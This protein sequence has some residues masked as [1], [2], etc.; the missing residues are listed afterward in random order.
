MG[1]LVGI[2]WLVV[3]LICGAAGAWLYLRRG[4][5]PDLL[6]PVRESLDRFDA[7]V[8]ELE[9]SRQ[10]AYGELREQVRGLAEGQE[11]LRSEAGRLASALRAPTVRGRWGEVQLRR[12][13]ELAGMV[14]HCD[15]LEQPTSEDG[16]H[17]PDMV[18]TL[19]GGR[20][21]VVDAKAPLHRYLDAVEAED[22][23]ARE[24]ALREHARHVRAHIARLSAKSYWSRFDDAPEF[25]V[26]FLPGEA[27]FSAALEQDPEL[28]EAGADDRVILAT[29]T[30]LIALLRSVAYGWR[31]E[32]V[33]RNAQEISELGREL[34]GRLATL[35]GH[36]DGVGRNLD[37][38]VRA[39]NDAVGSLEAR[40]L[41]SARRFSELGAVGDD[42]LE[43]PA[44]VVSMTRSVDIAERDV[45]G[46]PVDVQELDDGPLDRG[47]GAPDAEERTG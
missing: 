36:L 31:Q 32:Q 3:G 24:R 19:P 23:G 9:A 26:L 5:E 37:R 4:A 30:T 22:D 39:Y 20:H 44:R 2:V 16:R 34:H 28:I 18:V 7:H 11:R 6:A 12:V 21:V 25:V 14:E 15:F 17:R 47:G 29:P 46:R 40:V 10:Y 33:A 43:E 42:D 41:V 45:D 8:R 27:F 35:A 1:D 13:V 38:A